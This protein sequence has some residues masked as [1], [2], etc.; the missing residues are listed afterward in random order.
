MRTARTRPV[1]QVCPG[2]WLCP[3]YR[4]DRGGRWQTQQTKDL[5]LEGINRCRLCLQPYKAGGSWLD[6]IWD[7]SNSGINVKG[8]DLSPPRRLR[9]WFPKLFGNYGCPIADFSGN[10]SKVSSSRVFRRLRYQYFRQSW[11]IHSSYRLTVRFIRDILRCK[12]PAQHAASS[13]QNAG[14]AHCV[15]SGTHDAGNS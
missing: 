12:V 15:P 6:A 14:R 4:L 13:P 5:G 8:A 3:G 7:L 11:F 9:N 1:D 2:C 10:C